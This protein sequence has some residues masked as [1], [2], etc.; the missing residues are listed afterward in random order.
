MMYFC[1]SVAGEIYMLENSEL[2]GTHVCFLHACVCPQ[3]LRLSED[4]AP[5]CEKAA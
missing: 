2:V 3:R 5:P 1:S 4:T